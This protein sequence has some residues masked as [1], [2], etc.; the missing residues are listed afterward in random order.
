VEGRVSIRHT[1]RQKTAGQEGAAIDYP[2]KIK[3]AIE[4][5]IAAGDSAEGCPATG[6]PGQQLHKAAHS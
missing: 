2:D 5:S 1:G 3:K 6:L 4:G